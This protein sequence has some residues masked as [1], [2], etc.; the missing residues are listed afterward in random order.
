MPRDSVLLIQTMKNF[1]GIVLALI[2]EADTKTLACLGN[3]ND[4]HKFPD[5][6][7]FRPLEGIGGGQRS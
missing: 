2:V 1:H 4:R 7:Q 5:V 6:R 3:R